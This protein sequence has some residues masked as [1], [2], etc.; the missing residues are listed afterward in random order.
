MGLGLTDLLGG[1]V[2]LA[3]STASG[4]WP[5][6]KSGKL[7]ALAITASRPS[8]L[9][10]GIPTVASTGLQGYEAA[11]YDFMLALAKTP[12]PIINRLNR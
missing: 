10:P 4:V 2:Q 6:I 9:A 12:T 11:F 5:H 7:K 1:Q 8:A 3:F